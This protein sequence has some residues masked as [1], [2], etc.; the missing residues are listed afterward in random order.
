VTTPTPG[1]AI[2][3]RGFTAAL[4]AAI[5][6]LVF[7]VLGVA[8]LVIGLAGGPDAF[9]ILGPIFVGAGLLFAGAWRLL[10]TRAR[11]AR[12]RE[13][14]LL[15]ARANATL[16]DIELHPY[17]RIG[18]LITATLTVQFPAGTFSRRLTLSPLTRLERGQQL[19]IVYDPNDPATFRLADG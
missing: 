6:A 5:L 14:A 19:E 9:V 18:S 10:R 16:V 12:E 11:A 3:V 17:V 8:Y 13:D 4:V 15:R 7:G 1:T 2:D